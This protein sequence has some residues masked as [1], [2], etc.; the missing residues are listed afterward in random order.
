[1]KGKLLYKDCCQSASS[2]TSYNFIC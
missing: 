2:S 1:M